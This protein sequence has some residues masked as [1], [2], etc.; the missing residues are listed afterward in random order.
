MKYCI[1]TFQTRRWAT[2]EVM[3]GKVG[4][5][6]NNPIRLQSMTTSPT[7]D[8]EATVEQ[9]IRLADLG[10]DL[11]RVTVQGKKEAFACEKI[12]N[13]LLQKGYITP[14]VADIHFFPAAAEIV[15]DFVDKVRINPGNYL[16]RRATFKQIFYTD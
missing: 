10:C 6:G 1:S 11:V 9:I 7:D 12:K 13:S 2:R 15:V 3:V 8:V 5:G 14:L 4:I 16:D